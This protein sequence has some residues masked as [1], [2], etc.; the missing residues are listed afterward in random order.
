M[1]E[2]TLVSLKKDCFAKNTATLAVGNIF[3]QIINIAL[4]PLVT[5]L[6]SP[7]VF[8]I[9][10]IVFSV[11]IVLTSISSLRYY[12]AILLPENE[13]DADSLALLSF[14]LICVT[15]T[16]I[17]IATY[18]FKQPL[19]DFMQ[20]QPHANLLYLVPIGIFLRS[21]YV[22]CR[23]WNL[24]QKK[25]KQLSL[26]IVTGA[27]T[28]RV[29]TLSAGF[30]GLGPIGMISGRFLGHLSSFLTLFNFSDFLERF[31]TALPFKRISFVATR[32]KK[33]P[34]YA[35]SSLITPLNH[36]LPVILL[37]LFFS[38][39]IVGFYALAKRVLMQPMILIGDAVANSFLQRSAEY[40]RADKPLNEF[41]EYVFRFLVFSSL[42]PMLLL[43]LVA[44]DVF[45]FIFGNQWGDAG[46]YCKLLGPAIMMLFW[47]RPIQSFY[48]LFEKQK[49]RLIFFSVLLFLNTAALLTGGMLKNEKI[50]IGLYSL[51]SM[52]AYFLSF[53]GLLAQVN[54]KGIVIFRIV[55]KY[56]LIT[57]ALLC[58]PVLPKYFLAESSSLIILSS[59]FCSMIIYGLILFCKEPQFRSIIK[60]L[61]ATSLFK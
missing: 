60:L 35:F 53:Y 12:I 20:L 13:E 21:L 49:E 25:F 16:S 33:F 58:I 14:L 5:R 52:S 29:V 19:A 7:H 36:E 30:A 55:G 34:T 11:V 50:A 46:L 15:S 39:Q 8:G 18:F 1:T 40:R 44:E 42:F 26:S 56:L 43:A 38:P 59:A 57:S 45:A 6:Y 3:S 24:R 47:A 10:S 4:I 27:L 61:F 32:Y 17:W 28:D 2:K 41:A 54:V 51:S 48:D 37:G 31:F 9:C 23:F 22:V